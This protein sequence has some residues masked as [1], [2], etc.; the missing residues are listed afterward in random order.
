[1]P[2]VD[3]AALA[4][5]GPLNGSPAYRML[6]DDGR[7][8]P[9]GTY[10]PFNA[11][12]PGYF[13]TLGL[14]LVAGRLFD[15]RDREAMPPV[16]IVNETMASRLWPGESALGQR[17]RV[18]APID[19]APEVVG[20]VADATYASLA[21][22]AAPFL[23]YP[24]AQRLTGNVTVHLRATG[25]PAL[26]GPPAQQ[27]LRALDPSLPL[28][29]PRTVETLV[30]E[31]LWAPSFA[32]WL[33]GL[34]GFVAAALAGTGIHAIIGETLNQRRHEIG[35]RL[36]L[37]ASPGEMAT[38]IARKGLAPVLAGL[39]LGIAAAVVAL[40]S[41]RDLLYGA[42]P[43]FSV[44]APAAALIALAAVSACALPARR[45]MRID[46]LRAMRAE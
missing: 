32:A 31:S 18:P 34:F 43:A 9:N 6:A 23:Y 5:T 1:M 17:L 14:R 44:I 41:L 22:A 29:E 4:G 38:F 7:L 21:E 20:V 46:P 37:G 36:A 10:L 27:R 24:L 35:V 33:L 45:A 26:L 42:V 25:D 30:R 15:D 40:P 28:G 13:E 39:A 16:M 2:G 12:T 19:I 8:G 3:G 11:V